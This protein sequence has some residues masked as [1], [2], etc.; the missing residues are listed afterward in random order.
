VS[1]QQACHECHQLWAHYISAL[2]HQSGV[3]RDLYFARI[4]QV[5]GSVEA[6][7]KELEAVSVTTRALRASISRHEQANHAARETGTTGGA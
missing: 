2:L 3:E 1:S 4:E 6:L 5:A 7:Q